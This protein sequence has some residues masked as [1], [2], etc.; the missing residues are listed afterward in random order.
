MILRRCNAVAKRPAAT[1]PTRYPGA[2]HLAK[3]L[4]CNTRPLRSNALAGLGRRPK[5]SSAYTS[6]SMSAVSCFSSSCDQLLLRLLRHQR[7]A[8]ILEVRHQPTRAHRVLAGECAPAPRRRHLP[9]AESG[10]LSLAGAEPRSPAGTRRT[11]ATRSRR[12]HRARQHLKRQIQ[13][14]ECAGGDDDLLRGH[15]R[16]AAQ[17]AP[18]DLVAQLCAARRQVIQGAPGVHLPRC[19]AQATNRPPDPQSRLPDQRVRVAR[20]APARGAQARGRIPRRGGRRSRP[21]RGAGAGDRARLALADAPGGAGRRGDGAISLG[22]SG[23]R[24]LTD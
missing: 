5:Y 20:S 14:F 23:Q 4:Q 11:R 3:E 22:P 12:C 16:A 17:I 21:D 13:A 2:R 9:P 24:Q 1:H 18:C 7:T 8:G 6:S 15:A 19:G 10:S